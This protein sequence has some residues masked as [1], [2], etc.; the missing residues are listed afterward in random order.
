MMEAKKDQSATKTDFSGF[1]FK[2]EKNLRG[3]MEWR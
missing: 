3:Q 1:S 2:W